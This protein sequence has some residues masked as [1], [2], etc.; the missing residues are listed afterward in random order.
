MAE[1]HQRREPRAWPGQVGLT[2][3]E[4]SLFRELILR[5]LGIA[6]APWK[7]ALVISRLMP[8]LR[9]LGLT[10]FSDYYSLV[11][12][13]PDE[14]IRMFDCICTNKT[15][16]FREPRQFEYLEQQL[17][18]M[19]MAEAA[20][21]RRSRTLRVWSAACSTGEEPYSVAM[22]LSYLLPSASGWKIDIL[23]T[24]VSTR[25]LR[26]ASE[27]V[28]PIAR[29]A[30]IPAHLQKA[31]LLRGF[32]DNEGRMRIGPEIRA[33][34]QFRRLNLN[35]EDA[36]IATQFDLVL[37]RNVLIYFGP[38]TRAAVLQRLSDRVLP[39]GYL[40]L[41]HTESL[42]AKTGLLSPVIPTIYRRPPPAVRGTP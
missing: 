15:S 27:A 35:A 16:F 10:S 29:A 1:S 5:E 38:E 41:G 12:Q 11:L 20:A 4:F 37:C 40:F 19:W 32:G 33:T 34:V 31:F 14:Q 13:D 26:H 8:R 7:K 17:V 30:E 3:H 6:L 25:V 39:G 21:G 23:A 24:D 18:P 28:W 22:L 36:S 9:A 2:S 42:G